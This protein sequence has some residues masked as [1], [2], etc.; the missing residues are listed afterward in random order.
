MSNKEINDDEIRIISS[1]GVRNVV[2]AKEK[3]G[4]GLWIAVVVIVLIVVGVVIAALRGCDR[5]EAAAEYQEV[6]EE[7]KNQT[8]GD[9]VTGYDTKL[10]ADVVSATDEALHPRAYV[11]VRDTVVGSARLTILTPENAAAELLVGVDELSDSTIV[12]A[13]QAADIRADNGEI[14]SAFVSRGELLSTGQRKA[15][16]CA[17]VDGK[18]TL[19]VADATPCFEQALTSGGYFFRQYPLV[20]G[21]QVVENKPKGK[22]IRRAL[23]E[24]GGREVVIISR[25]ELT[26][27]Q[28]SQALVDLGVTTA[29]YLVGSTSYG[30]AVIATGDTLTMNDSFVHG[31]PQNIN[32]IV[33]K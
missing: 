18:I 19:G 23:A 22:S 31:A 2:P 6:L 27:G 15:G 11:T 3:R 32:F 16:F 9:D 24:L 30:R 8:D 1:S 7:H 26:F 10:P 29:I 14:V 5:G 4:R 20:V 12:M 25:N 13:F 17:I 21:N 33:W 28:F